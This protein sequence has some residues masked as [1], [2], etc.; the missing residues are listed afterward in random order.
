M[1]KESKDPTLYQDSRGLKHKPRAL[2]RYV[3]NGI[4]SHRRPVEINPDLERPLTPGV[5]R[6]IG[7]Q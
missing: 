1:A 6:R 7:D 4:Q 5:V 3:M 2:P